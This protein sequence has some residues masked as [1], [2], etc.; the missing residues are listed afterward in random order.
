MSALR[1]PS[2]AEFCVLPVVR[3]GDATNVSELPPWGGARMVE[4]PALR[5]EIALS[6]TADFLM[7]PARK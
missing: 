2:E 5:R 4:L 7:G 6:S 1:R 3:D